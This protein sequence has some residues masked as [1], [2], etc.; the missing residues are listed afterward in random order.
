MWGHRSRHTYLEC[1]TTP[2]ERRRSEGPLIKGARKEGSRRR[3]NPDDRA[4][5]AR[6]RAPSTLRCA[7]RDAKVRW[8]DPPTRDSTAAQGGAE[9]ATTTTP[10]CPP[11]RTNFTICT[12]R[13]VAY[14]CKSR[15]SEPRGSAEL[16]CRLELYTKPVRMD[17]AERLYTFEG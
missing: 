7:W 1:I 8:G 4:Y 12:R 14:L 2:P 6:V 17:G 10:R 3:E 15:G 9:N 16:R 13:Q 11:P 5:N